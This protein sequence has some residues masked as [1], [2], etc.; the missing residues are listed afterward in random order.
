MGLV[1]LK[2][3]AN[4]YGALNGA[5]KRTWGLNDPVIPTILY[6]YIVYQ[7]FG[8]I[9]IKANAWKKWCSRP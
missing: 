8:G 6:I 5:Q 1:W 7:G 2:M 3:Y 4:N 9:F